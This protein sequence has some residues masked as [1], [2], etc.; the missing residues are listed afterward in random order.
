MTGT[1]L[2]EIYSNFIGGTVLKISQHFA[3][4]KQKMWC[5]F[6]DMV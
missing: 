3:N 2:S 4:S 6:P 5:F 1:A